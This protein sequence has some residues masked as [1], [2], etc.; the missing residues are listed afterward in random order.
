MK[1]IYRTGWVLGV[2]LLVVAGLGWGHAWRLEQR[3][4][5][6]AE[7][8]R[9]AIALLSAYASDLKSGKWDAVAAHYQPERPDPLHGFVE[10]LVWEK[11]DV[12][13]Y[14]WRED[15]ASTGPLLGLGPD[16]H[17]DYCKFK[18]DSVERIEAPDHM[19]IKA[20]LWI[21]ASYRE[22][23]LESK[24]IMRLE[25]AAHESEWKI[26][27]QQILQGETVI[28]PGEG[29]GDVASQV[30]IDFV[31]RENPIY[32]SSQWEPKRFEIFKYASGGVS[33]S[34]I[35]GD[36]WGDLL[37][38]DGGSMCLF[39]N[40]GD[41]RFEDETVLWGLNPEDTG[42]NAALFADFD[43]DGL[44]DLFLTGLTRPSRMLRN[45]GRRFV[46]V[47]GVP[48]GGPFV[49][50]AAAADADSDGDLDLVFGRYL[51]PRTKLPT[52][53]SYTR[54]GEGSSF[55]RNLGD[56]KFVDATQEVGLNESG[57]TLGL[58]W[59]DIDADGDL[60][61]YVANDFGRN[62]L[63][64]NDG[65]GYFSDV[66]RSSGTVDFGFGMSASFADADNDGDLDLYVSNVRSGQR[67]YSQAATLYLYLINS[68]KQGTFWEDYPLYREVISLSGERW[69][70][71]GDKMVKGNALLINDG[72]GHFTDIAMSSCANPFGWYWGSTLF[73]YDND[74][75]QD[76]YSA[77]GWITAELKDDL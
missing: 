77:N 48:V 6:L 13:Y 57:L 46:Q 45:D 71:Y 74:G 2:L 17:I 42:F 68:M 75:D 39:R 60:D 32:H 44:K 9:A 15:L 61:L 29:F 36:G 18:L 52:T 70:H 21:R 19:T 37:F 51:D 63:Y 23:L 47:E 62:A 56:F 67:W 65:N 30:G 73:D 43:N 41:G 58:A 26:A 27:K 54:N 50:V 5:T 40:Q 20:L 10:V 4:L 55:L 33:T 76:I 66:T 31:A 49:T 59:G 25:L 7:S 53:L 1:R 35:D 28:G 22:Q 34:D 16:A 64:E 11:S 69:H 8:G 3:A 72:Q 24:A 12:A 38:V 14:R